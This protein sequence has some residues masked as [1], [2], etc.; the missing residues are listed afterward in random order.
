MFPPQGVHRVIF[1]AVLNLSRGPPDSNGE[2]ILCEVRD[3]E[4]I[5]LP[6]RGGTVPAARPRGDGNR[7]RAPLA[8]IGQRLRPDRHGTRSP[9]GSRRWTGAFGH[10]V[11]LALRQRPLTAGAGSLRSSRRVAAARGIATPKEAAALHAR[12]SILTIPCYSR[13]TSAE[14]AAGVGFG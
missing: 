8:R 1:T 12:N 5:L 11:I 4:P 3:D 2:G 13:T 9:S 6:W 14:Y 7:R 10:P